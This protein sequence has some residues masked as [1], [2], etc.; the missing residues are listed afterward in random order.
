MAISY[1]GNSNNYNN[2]PRKNYNHRSYPKKNNYQQ[3]QN[4]GPTVNILDGCSSSRVGSPAQ[5]LR[6]FC[7]KNRFPEPVFKTISIGKGEDLSYNCKVTVS[8]VY[9]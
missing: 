7:R 3:N 2:T 6:E 9:L 8:I 5:Y 1:H 4:N